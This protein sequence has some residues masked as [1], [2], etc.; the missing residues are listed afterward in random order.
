[1]N[2]EKLSQ[3]ELKKKKTFHILILLSAL[4]VI[5]Y[6][7]LNLMA[8]ASTWYMKA[9]L[10]SFVCIHCWNE[11]SL[12]QPWLKTWVGKHISGFETDHHK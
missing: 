11:F 4:F 9:D 5:H 2:I 1:M 10:T 6:D 7:L 8:T 3:L 12:H